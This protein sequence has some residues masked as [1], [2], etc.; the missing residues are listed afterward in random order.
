M[1]NIYELIKEQ[2][3]IFDK[4]YKEIQEGYKELDIIEKS[5]VVTLEE[6]H[7]VSRLTN[8]KKNTLL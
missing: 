6:L 3:K 1:E 5:S 2:E 4:E 8:N 7:A